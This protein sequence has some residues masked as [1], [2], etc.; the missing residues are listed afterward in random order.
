MVDYGARACPTPFLLLTPTAP[1]PARRSSRILRSDSARDHDRVLPTT[2]APDP[3]PFLRSIAAGTD[4]L[5]L[6]IADYVV[7][8]EIKSKEAVKTA[9]YAILDS[10]G[11]AL[12][13]LNFPE[14]TKLL[15]PVVPGVRVKH[16]ARVIGTD[17]DL[18]PVTAAHNTATA[19]RWLDYNDAWLA[20]EWVHPSDVVGAILPLAEYLSRVRLE[21]T[22]PPLTMRDV[23]VWTIKAY[24]LVGVL[25]LEN[26]L[27]QIGVD[28]VLMTRVAVA[29]VCARYRAAVDARLPAPASQA[30]LADGAGLRCFR[31]YPNNGTRKGWAAGDAASRGV[32]IALT[33]MRGEM[34]YRLVLSAPVWGFNDVFYRRNDLTVRRD[35]EEHVAEHTLFKVSFP[36]EYHTQTAVEAAFRLHPQV[37]HRVDEVHNV[38]IHTTR[39]AV[40]C[41]DK[42]RA[43]AKP[44]GQ[45][46]LPAVR[47]RRGAAVRDGDRGALRRGDRGGSTHR[48]TSEPNDRGGRSAVQ[49]RLPRPRAPIGDKRRAG[50][51]SGSHQ[52]VQ[53]GGRVPARPPSPKERVFSRAREE[54]HGGAQHP[55]A[56]DEG[57]ASLRDVRGSPEVRRDGGAR[58]CGA[59][60]ARARALPPPAHA[61]GSGLP[62]AAGRGR[63]G[64]GGARVWRGWGLG[65]GTR[66]ERRRRPEDRL[67][68][69]VIFRARV[70][71]RRAA[72]RGGR[73]A[74]Q[75]IY[76]SLSNGPTANRASA[77][78][79][80]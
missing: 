11:C 2:R 42:T 80:S 19:V 57:G 71:L 16:G 50:A 52:H 63:R 29:A 41:V 30:W 77:S 7:G 34:G 12:M 21:R 8:Y 37:V 61:R 69:E 58:L 60:L 62:R 44:G 3:S 74:F 39:S 40:R 18:D 49:R 33:T 47:R 72:P 31:H 65:R 6:D 54:V 32:W 25:A 10:V 55:H 53:G 78:N 4:Q 43:S 70:G 73:E 38:T 5:L 68:G 46:S 76:G 20:S 13:S 14:C 48:R 36:A 51:F 35:F 27:N 66:R 59:L 67:P 26:S 9:R 22:L 15:G 45:G 75:Y 56:P 28:H 17:H 23:V 64:S 24:E 1:R 79:R